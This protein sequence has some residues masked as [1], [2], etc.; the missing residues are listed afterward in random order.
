MN[1]LLSG[2]TRSSSKLRSVR[3]FNLLVDYICSVHVTKIHVLIFQNKTWTRTTA[4][5]FNNQ[6]Y[7]VR[8]GV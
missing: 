2:E 5:D 7:R 3:S 8:L 4:V 1:F 6:R